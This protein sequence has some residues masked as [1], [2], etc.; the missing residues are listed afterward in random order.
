MMI[1][2]IIIATII[3]GFGCTTMNSYSQEIRPGNKIQNF[4]YIP[5]NF[6]LNKIDTTL[7]DSIQLI[8]KHYSLMNTYAKAYGKDSDS[9]VYR[10]RDYA[11]EI[12]LII[13]GKEIIKKKLLKSDF[14]TDEK[15]WP[16]LTMYRV[17]LKPTDCEN[18]QIIL[19]VG[20]GIPNFSTPVIADLILGYDGKTSI[21]LR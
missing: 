7:N 17:W 10:Y 12:N 4:E 21:K 6:E 19:R 11:L 20:I 16:N 3:L 18:N 5:K 14:I 15:Y 1:G 13:S 8:A 9:T 2:K